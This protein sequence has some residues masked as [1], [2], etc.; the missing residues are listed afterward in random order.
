MQ[1]PSKSDRIQNILSSLFLSLGF[2]TVSVKRSSLIPCLYLFSDFFLYLPFTSGEP[3]HQLVGGVLYLQRRLVVRY[4]IENSVHYHPIGPAL[5]PLITKRLQF[6][7]S[8]SLNQ[9]KSVYS[10][11]LSNILATCS[12]SVPTRER[13]A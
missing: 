12:N 6:T 3:I 13:E 7:V 9:E 8:K 10:E 4:A 1:A 11:M 5:R 2:S